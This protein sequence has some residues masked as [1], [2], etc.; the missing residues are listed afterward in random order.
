MLSKR[1][2]NKRGRWKCNEITSSWTKESHEARAAARKER[3]A[4]RALNQIRNHRR[5][6]Q[7]RSKQHARQ[8]HSKR[9]PRD[10]YRPDV[11]RKLRTRGDEE[12]EDNHQ[13]RRTYRIERRERRTHQR[14][15]LNIATH[16]CAFCAFLW[17][18][19]RNT[20]HDF[21]FSRTCLHR[22][23]A[24]AHAVERTPYEEY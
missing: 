18:V 10:R 12:A 24:N 11:N 9:L 1:A 2:G 22:R 14:V 8:Q 13:P 17:L 23:R 21:F 16:L 20:L 5:R 4:N 15:S 19:S 7:T 6:A 3:Q